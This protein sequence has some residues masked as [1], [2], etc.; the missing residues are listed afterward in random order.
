MEN[1][2]FN[3]KVDEDWKKK[4]R[5]QKEKLESQIQPK[6]KEE[7]DEEMYDAPEA[8]FSNFVLSLAS[9]TVIHLGMQKNPMTGKKEIN[10]EQA[11]YTIDILQVLQEK[12]KKNLDKEEENLL[13]GILYDL[14][15]RYV[16]MSSETKKQPPIPS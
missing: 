15:M 14:Q 11:N 7:P 4:A 5:E 2:E 10:L 9:Q 1:F 16:K 13:N 12:T 8:N 3:K 6:Q